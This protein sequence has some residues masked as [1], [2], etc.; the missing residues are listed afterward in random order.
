MLSRWVFIIEISV[1]LVSVAF[2][3]EPVKY[4]AKVMS[5]RSPLVLL[6]SEPLNMMPLASRRL[7]LEALSDSPAVE[8]GPLT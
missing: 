6:S 5:R 7:H 3:P 8:C 1:V 4:K 2:K